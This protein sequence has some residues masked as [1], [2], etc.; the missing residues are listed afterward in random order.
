MAYLA[1]A[2]AAACLGF[3]LL[4]STKSAVPYPLYD[5]QL[6]AAERMED[7]EKI[8][9]NALL[10]QGISIETDLDPNE[11]GLIGPEWTILTTTLG[12]LEAKRSSLNPNFA[13]LMVRFFHEAG[14][15]AGDFI[16]VGASGSFP[17]LTIATLCAAEEMGL[18][19]LTIASFGAS[20]YGATRPEFTTPRM[21]QILS[22]AAIIPN[23]LLAVSPGADGDYGENPLFED[24]RAIIAGLA[25]ETGVEF[26]D[27]GP[28]NLEAS[29]SRRL[30]LFD[31]ASDGGKIACFVNIGGA[32]PNSG[33]SPYTLDFPQGLVLSP[34]R[35]PLSANR[36]LVYE[37]AA[38]GVPVINLLNIRSLAAQNGLPYDPIPLPR[39]GEGDVYKTVRYNKPLAIATL[40][41]A[42]GL[43]ALAVL[44]R[45]KSG[46]EAK[47]S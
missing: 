46:K 23:S 39:P 30:Q 14:L 16:A 40:A 47:S 34:P 1:G 5:Q 41:V 15:K 2:V 25:A 10:L 32:S 18:N 36:G 11:T 26:I 13:A 4:Q 37:Y 35:I 3:I 33:T 31:E 24:S 8:L 12:D 9:K 17:G 21:I 19:T 22:D 29:I 6:G 43:L 27:F 38:R 42:I 7:A 20:M 44:R 45:G 28:T